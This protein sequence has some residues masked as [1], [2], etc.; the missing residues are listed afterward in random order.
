MCRDGYHLG[1]GP[2][3]PKTGSH[4]GESRGQRKRASRR[5]AVNVAETDEV[6]KKNKMP[7][8]DSPSR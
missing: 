8:K 4:Y 6:T 5:L 2:G 1:K 7:P 3:K